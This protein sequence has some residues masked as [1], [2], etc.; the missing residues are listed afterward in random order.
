M[1]ARR[2]QTT[3]PD[4][5]TRRIVAIVFVSALTFSLV[6]SLDSGIAAPTSEPASAS[7]S[8]PTELPAS[9]LMRE[10]ANGGTA[11]DTLRRIENLSTTLDEIATQVMTAIDS[12]W[13]RI[14]G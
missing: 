9:Q 13:V 4:A 5:A 14:V 11:D 7:V 12:V 8:A 3:S 1:P 6:V 10:D 2:S